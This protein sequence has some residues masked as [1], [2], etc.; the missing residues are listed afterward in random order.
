MCDPVTVA[1][2]VAVASTG[3]QIQQSRAQGKFQKGVADF[4][5]RTAEN[6][7]E[8]TRTSATAAENTKR[9]RTAELLS[10]QRAQLGAAGVALGSG[11]AL[12]LQEDT[13]TLG[14]ADALRIRERGDDAFQA[15]QTEASLTESQGVFAKAAAQSKAAGSLLT[16]AGAV[17]DTGVADKWFTSKSVG[18]P[19]NINQGGGIGL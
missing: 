2:V 19:L 18:N 6:E 8:A 5:A 16:G 14:E 9:Q 11:S 13:L 1:A 3:F 12:Q 7:A 17:L 4:N 15:L 10:K